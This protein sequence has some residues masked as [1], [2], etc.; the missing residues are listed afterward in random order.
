MVL[1]ASQHPVYHFLVFISVFS[2]LLSGMRVHGAG[3]SVYLSHCCD[4]GVEKCSAHSRTN[5]CEKAHPDVELTELFT[6][7]WL[8][9]NRNLCDLPQKTDLRWGPDGAALREEMGPRRCLIGCVAPWAADSQA[10]R[11]S[12]KRRD[13]DRGELKIQWGEDTEA[14]SKISFELLV[15]LKHPW[16]RG[17]R[18]IPVVS[19]VL[20]P[21]SNKEIVWRQM[22][23]L[24]DFST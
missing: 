16:I 15:D 21:T 22:F 2:C 23:R 3:I 11:V 10:M 1:I 20:N 4:T 13:G 24:I 8:R 9:K 18:L 12:L 7:K 14:K 5:L 17:T 19:P 6:N